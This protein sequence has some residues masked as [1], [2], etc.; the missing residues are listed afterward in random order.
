MLDWL[1]LRVL[2]AGLAR[3]ESFTQLS[4]RLDAVEVVVHDVRE[5]VMG[6][7]EAK[8]SRPITKSTRLRT[9]GRFLRCLC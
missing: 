1:G 3:T 7:D 4:L 8:L 9:R 5:D 6:S 2:H